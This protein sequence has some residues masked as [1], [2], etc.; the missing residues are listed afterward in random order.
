MNYA[1]TLRLNLPEDDATGRAAAVEELRSLLAEWRVDGQA[2]VEA[3]HTRE[4]LYE[5]PCVSDSPELILE[6]SLRDGYTYTMLPSIRAEAGQTW[7]TLDPSEYP[8]GKGL[9]MN[10]TH[11]QHGLLA[12]WGRGV[13]AGAEVS[14]GMPDIAPTLLHLMGEAVP[15]HMDG[16]VLQAAL[17][18]GQTPVRHSAPEASP[19]AAPTSATSEEAEAIRRRL[20]RLGY[21]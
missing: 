20:E 17:S 21:L 4:A 13:Q 18:S 9:G 3:V 2:V 11:R 14:A 7:R 15:G 19:R 5:G 10:G 8:G 12:L 6:L 16:S 1:A